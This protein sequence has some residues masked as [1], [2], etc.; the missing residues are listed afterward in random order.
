MRR[1]DLVICGG[2]PS[3]HAAARAYREARGAGTVLL[4]SADER[5]PYFRP[6]LSK[7]YLRGETADE[8]LA[9]DDAGWYD[10]H[11]V[12]VELATAAHGF[13]PDARV[14]LLAGESVA[15]GRLL[16]A[17]GAEPASLP[18]PGGDDPSV[19]RLRRP[20]DSERIRAAG[21]RGS[22]TVVGSGFIGC[23]AAASLAMRG[24]A[25]RLIGEEPLPQQS[26]LGEEAG[27]RIAGWLLELGVELVLGEPVRRIDEGR[28]V[29][30]DG[31]RRLSAD[32][33]VVGAGIVPNSAIAAAAGLELERDRIPCDASM[34]TAADGVLA[35]GDAALAMNR[36]AGRRLVVQHWG[37]AE[38]MGEVAGRTA[39]GAEDVWS[40]APGFWSGIGPH[41]LKHV[42]WGDGHDDVRLLDDHG[43]DVFAIL[44]GREGT[45]VGALTSERD[46]VYDHA[47]PL[48]ERGTSL[49]ESTQTLG[50]LVGARR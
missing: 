37:E 22:V 14:V 35:A 13:D 33:V 5:L 12:D 39:A 34:R 20:I 30:L 11:R 26:L 24:S 3:G 21:D 32:A 6:P 25:V 23:E 8:D 47:R 29:E 1:Y 18:V 4:V 45:L 49:D 41:T 28:T 44:Y 15:Y 31:G 9:L 7:D 42:A 2:G 10:A 19:L 36:A 40:Q 17:T 16:L 27:R 43:P 50:R 38:R 48:I 46:E